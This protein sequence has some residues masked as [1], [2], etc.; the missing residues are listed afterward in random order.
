MMDDT[1]VCRLADL[2]DAAKSKRPGASSQ[3]RVVNSNLKKPPKNS[4]F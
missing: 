2:L 1:D 3:G 4:R